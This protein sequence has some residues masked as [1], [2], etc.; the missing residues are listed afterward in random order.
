MAKPKIFVQIASYRDPELQNTLHDLLSRASDKSRVFIGICLQLHKEKDKTFFDK[1]R[2]DKRVRV[3][4][5]SHTASKGAGWAR[6][7]AAKLRKD[8]EYTLVIDSHMR[9]VDGWDE[10]MLE[11]LKQTGSD[12]A[13]LST[14]PAGYTLP[15]QRDEGWSFAITPTRFD[16][17]GV[18]LFCGKARQNIADSTD[19]TRGCFSTARFMF[20]PSRMFD[21]VP[22][23]PNVFLYDEEI[24]YA[25]RAFTHGWD[26][27]HPLQNLCFHHWERTYRPTIFDDKS[28]WY[29]FSAASNLYVK[30][31][32]GMEKGKPVTA[33]KYKLGKVRS[34]EEFELR[35]GITLSK[36]VISHEAKDAV[37]DFDS[38]LAQL[39]KRA[40][41]PLKKLA[42]ISP[43]WQMDD[44]QAANNNRLFNINYFAKG[45]FLDRNRF[46]PTTL[47]GAP[48]GVLIVENYLS[49]VICQRL[50]EYFDGVAGQRLQV[51]DPEKTTKK[52]IISRDDPQRVTEY[53]PCDPV[54]PEITSI[55]IDIYCNMLTPYFGIEYEWFERPQ[56]LRYYPGGTYKG[57]SDCEYVDAQGVWHKVQDR[58][59]S[60]LL[61]INNEFEGGAISF[62]KLN[63]KI[64]P[65]AGMLVAFPSHH[66]YLHEAESVTAGKRYAIVTWAAQFGVQRFMEAAPYAS[67]F[68]RAR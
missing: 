62:P 37:F 61:Y 31:L 68:I 30:Q 51:I 4:H 14:Y 53:V 35:S 26:V 19:S 5:F 11:C 52:E 13:F 54:M 27:Y 44:E 60:V 57:H 40:K 16:D 29:D 24:I 22:F 63:Y 58:D 49:P 50:V 32:L 41:Q 46:K 10:R 20:A 42:S 65:K 48:E 18:L 45:D 67:V 3:A 8:E 36:R 23:D 47:E 1:K 56:V 59:T 33:S 6:A 9:F 38:T 34:L 12:K 55:F 66:G 25:A 39:R 43:A 2:W 21:A 64:Q 15:D 28:N 17:N 7:E